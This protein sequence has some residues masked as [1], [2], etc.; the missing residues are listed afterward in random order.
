MPFKRVAHVRKSPEAVMA[1]L[2]GR[3]TR[4]HELTRWLGEGQTPR[5]LSPEQLGLVEASLPQPRAV[6]RHR[7]RPRGR[8]AFHDEALRQQQRQR[9][10]QPPPTSVLEP[11]ESDLDRP[12]VRNSRAKPGKRPQAIAAAAAPAGGLHL[13][14]AA[15]AQRLFEAPDARAAASAEPGAH[16]LTAPTPWRQEEIEEPAAHALTL[17]APVKPALTGHPVPAAY[18]VIAIWSPR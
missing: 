14:A 17:R 2:R 12:F 11:L 13:R 10:R 5:Q 8:E 9:L 4:A 6:E 18:Y 16:R 3:R 7:D 1:H 15:A